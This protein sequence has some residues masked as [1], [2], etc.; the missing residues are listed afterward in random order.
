MPGMVIML[1]KG[2]GAGN[3]DRDFRVRHTMC[4]WRLLPSAPGCWHCRTGE[5]LLPRPPNEPSLAFY[6]FCTNLFQWWHWVHSW[7]FAGYQV[8]S[9]WVHRYKEMLDFRGSSTVVIRHSIFLIVHQIIDN[10]LTPSLNLPKASYCKQT[11]SRTQNEGR[12]AC[13]S[14][15]SHTLHSSHSSLSPWPF[16]L[17]SSLQWNATR[18]HS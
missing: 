1:G 18:T 10:Q 14:V 5:P 13:V 12:H 4:S 3:S 8:Y 6:E 15:C 2:R 17:L 11:K 16:L 9:C 7:K